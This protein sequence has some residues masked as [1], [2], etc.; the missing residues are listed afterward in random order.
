MNLLFCLRL[1]QQQ[2][3]SCLNL[4]KLF[5]R[6]KSLFPSD[7]I[8]ILKV[9]NEVQVLIRIPNVFKKDYVGS[10]YKKFEVGFPIRSTNIYTVRYNPKFPFRLS[11]IEPNFHTKCI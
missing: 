9:I 5:A 2:L 6:S 1:S 7:H 3:S 11:F 8:T 10:M 4:A